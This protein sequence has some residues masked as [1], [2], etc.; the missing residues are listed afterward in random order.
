MQ[1]AGDKGKDDELVLKIFAVLSF[2]SRCSRNGVVVCCSVL[3]LIYCADSF[4]L[5]SDAKGVLRRV[6]QYAHYVAT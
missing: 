6:T 2:D 1:H 5:A 4:V 3:L